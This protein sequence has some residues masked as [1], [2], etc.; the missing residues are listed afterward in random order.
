MLLEQKRILYGRPD[1][2]PKTKYLDWLYSVEYND[3][4]YNNLSELLK[5]S[6][7]LICENQQTEDMPKQK[8]LQRK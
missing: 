1:G 3:V 6:C 5:A 4:P 7:I 8:I 2:A